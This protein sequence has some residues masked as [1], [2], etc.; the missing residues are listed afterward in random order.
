MEKTGVFPGVSV[1]G[2]ARECR[3]PR[4]LRQVARHASSEFRVGATADVTHHPARRHRPEIV[5]T[6][7]PKGPGTLHFIFR[8]ALATAVLAPGVH[9]CEYDTSDNTGC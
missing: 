5:P 9:T 6:H 7:V 1:S 2:R 8:A 3:V 4:R